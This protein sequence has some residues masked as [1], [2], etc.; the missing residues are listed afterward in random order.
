ME[1]FS[2]IKKYGIMEQFAAT[3][4]D[5]EI[6]ILTE[7][8]QTKKN[9]WY[10]LYAESKKMIQNGNFYTKQRET[11][12]HRQQTYA[13]QSGKRRRDILGVWD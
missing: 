2:A 5:L 11:H 6:I 12:R 4:M 9:T 3:G 13:Y 7:V 10:H 8:S 1:Y